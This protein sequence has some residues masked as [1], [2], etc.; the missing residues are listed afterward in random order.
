MASNLYR[1]VFALLSEV[2]QE[3]GGV[4]EGG[5]FDKELQYS[6]RTANVIDVSL[7]SR[8]KLFN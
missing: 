1:R 2:D 7:K 6:S 3:P 4:V 5:N 8:V